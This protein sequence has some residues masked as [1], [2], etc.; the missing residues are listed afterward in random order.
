[1]TIAHVKGVIELL[2]LK[3]SFCYRLSIDKTHRRFIAVARCASTVSRIVVTIMFKMCKNI[4]ILML[5]HECYNIFM[6]NSC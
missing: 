5:V 1:M 3:S 6:I 2:D 4:Y